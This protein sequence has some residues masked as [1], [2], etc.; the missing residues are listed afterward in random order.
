MRLTP[1]DIQQQQFH[2]C[3][4]P[5]DRTLAFGLAVDQR[6]T[7][8]MKSIVSRTADVR[9]RAIGANEATVSP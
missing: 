3:L 7:L 5:L 1:I 8:L 2:P 9:Q 6:V 4:P